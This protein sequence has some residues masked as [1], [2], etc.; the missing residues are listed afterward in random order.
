[1]H[2]A[3]NA[4]H[5]EVR[6]NER[7]IETDKKEWYKLTSRGKIMGKMTDALGFGGR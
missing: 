4:F 1:M 7:K 2:V 6:M 5:S 3:I